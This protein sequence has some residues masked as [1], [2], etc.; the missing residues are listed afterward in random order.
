MPEAGKKGPPSIRGEG[1]FLY[2]KRGVAAI[3]EVAQQHF[4]SYFQASLSLSRDLARPFHNQIEKDQRTI[5]DRH[6]SRHFM[7]V[8]FLSCEN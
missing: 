3:E 8:L 7:H 6:C 5:T 4:F 1:P 2:A